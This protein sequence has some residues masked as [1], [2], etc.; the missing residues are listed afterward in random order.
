MGRRKIEMKYIEKKT[1]R[2]ATYSK[3]KKGILKKANELAILCDAQ[4]CLIM[5]SDNG[6]LAEYISPSTTMKDIFD[7]YEKKTNIDLSASDQYE[8]ATVD[9]LKSLQNELRKQE[10]INSI[11][12]KEI[13]Q[14]SGQEELRGFSYGELCVLEEDLN[15][16]LASVRHHKANREDQGSHL[17]PRNAVP[18]QLTFPT[19]TKPAQSS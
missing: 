7:R 4:V 13:R 10:L 1:N 18:S 3:R 12:R 14:S 5:F 2:Q 6:K 15:H 11:L 16:S 17:N 19:A 9:L 8:V